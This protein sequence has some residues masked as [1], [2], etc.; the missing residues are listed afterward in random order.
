M[1]ITI[2]ARRAIDSV[3]K[4]GQEYVVEGYVYFSGVSAPTFGITCYTKGTGNGSPLIDGGPNWPSQMA[5]V[6]PQSSWLLPWRKI[7]ATVTARAWS[8]QLEYAFIKIAGSD[9]ANTGDF[10]LDDVTIRENTTGRFIYRRVIGP[11]VNS[12]GGTNAQGLYWINCAGNKLVIERSRIKGSLL[13][14]N[15]G[16][17]SMIGAGP[18]SWS[19]VVPGYPALLVHADIAANADFTIAATNRAVRMGRRRE[20]QSDRR[21]P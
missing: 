8:G 3:V 21:K 7:S 13:V 18:I 5:P 11:G 1:M 6:L 16:A 4:P 15:P 20:L 9:S 14:L 17:G 2:P 12:L 19:P 10:Y